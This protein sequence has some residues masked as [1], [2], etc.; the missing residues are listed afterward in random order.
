MRVLFFSTMPN[1]PTGGVRVIYRFVNLLNQM[2]IE[3]YVYHEL[4]SYR[5]KWADVSSPV[6]KGKYIDRDDHIVIPDVF[7]GRKSKEIRDQY[8][9]VSQRQKQNKIST[10]TISLCIEI[11]QIN[12]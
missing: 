10:G 9:P 7:I 11:T 2:G 8:C 1:A 5:Y 4:K 12:C 6:Y 3:S